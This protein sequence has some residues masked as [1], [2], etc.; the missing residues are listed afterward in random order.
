MVM[1]RLWIL[2]GKFNEMIIPLYRW[3]DMDETINEEMLRN[4]VIDMEGKNMEY[5]D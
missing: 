1:N 2:W 4:M 3:D 5:N